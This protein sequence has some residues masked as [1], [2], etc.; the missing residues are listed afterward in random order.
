MRFG[1]SVGGLTDLFSSTSNRRLADASRLTVDGGA[2][3]M[4]ELEFGKEPMRY[5]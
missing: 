5:W 3:P 2:E 1:R 4:A